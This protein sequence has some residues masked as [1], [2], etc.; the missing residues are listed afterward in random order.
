MAFRPQIAEPL[1]QMAG[2]LFLPPSTSS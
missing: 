1:G 2:E